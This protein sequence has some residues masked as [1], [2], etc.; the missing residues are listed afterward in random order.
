LKD[1]CQLVA[2]F[3]QSGKAVTPAVQTWLRDVLFSEGGIIQVLISYHYATQLPRGAIYHADL[4][5]QMQWCQKNIP[6]L[7]GL[8]TRLQEIQ[9]KLDKDW[10]L[11]LVLI[12]NLLFQAMVFA[13]T[14]TY[15][16]LGEKLL[17]DLLELARLVLADTLDPPTGSWVPWKWPSRPPSADRADAEVPPSPRYPVDP[18][19]PPLRS[20]VSDPGELVPVATG[21]LSSFH[22]EGSLWRKKIKHHYVRIEEGEHAGR[23]LYF[24]SWNGANARF[25]VSENSG[26]EVI[27]IPLNKEVSILQAS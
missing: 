14:T 15:P 22:K 3:P 19:A 10:Q 2:A 6:H 12:E 9:V 20:P 18:P 24:L 25:T 4:D 13:N 16:C 26:D 7:A 11:H 5:R 27:Y 8:V 17:Q 23:V 21:K 1:L